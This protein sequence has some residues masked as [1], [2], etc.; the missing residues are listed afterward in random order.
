VYDRLDT[1]DRERLDGM[2]QVFLDEKTFE[3]GQDLEITEE[4]RVT[5]AAQACIL[6]LG[7]N[8]KRIYPGLKSI[9]VYP[10]TY[11][12]TQRSVG[13]GGVVT[14]SNAP[15]AGES[16]NQTTGWGASAGGPVILSW[17]DVLR[18]GADVNDGHTVVYHEFAHQLDGQATG[19]DG[20]PPLPSRSRYIAWARVLGEEFKNLRRDLMMRQPTEIRAYGATNPAEFFAV[21][22]ETYFER[23]DALRARHPELYDQLKQ[24]YDWEP[25]VS[26]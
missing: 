26:T 2:I 1:Q 17:C 20:A 6:L 16:W 18:G 11:V 8:P 10:S 24:F 13:P 7:L 22:T 4:I 3:G 9:I 12:A 19:M 25:P 23:S 5:I 15:R 21:A 14:E